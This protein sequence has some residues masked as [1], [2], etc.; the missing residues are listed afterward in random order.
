MRQISHIIN[1]INELVGKGIS[2]LTTL[3]VL[4]ICYDVLMRYFFD[5]TSA[6]IIELE[7]HIFSLIFLIG[8][9]YCLKHDRHVRVDVFYTNFSQTAKSWINLLGTLFF[10][11]PF[12]AIVIYY[13]S[14]FTANSFALNES[15]SDPSGL[16]ARYLIKSA[17]P[18]GFFF[19]FLQGISLL[20]ESILLIS[21]GFVNKEDK[22]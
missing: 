10:L 5:S 19:L 7:W 20:M 6:G 22:V 13:S 8:A 1:K 15:S 11:L 14:K 16:P 18:I 2:W 3:L 21:R 12:C 4:V 17:I 9:G